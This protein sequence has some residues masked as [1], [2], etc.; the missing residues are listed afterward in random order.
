M[1]RSLILAGVAVATMAVSF[2]N[3]PGVSHN[4]VLMAVCSISFDLATMD[5][6]L[7]L[8]TGAEIE[9]IPDE[10]LRDGYA[11]ARHLMEG[12]VTVMDATPSLWRMIVESGWEGNTGARMA[13]SPTPTPWDEYLGT[14]AR[15]GRRAALLQLPG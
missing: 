15:T 3:E 10:E 5:I 7:P 11:L 4:D 1:R 8:T 6:F 13:F 2:A 9:L 14:S 12:R